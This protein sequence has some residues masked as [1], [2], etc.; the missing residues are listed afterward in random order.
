MAHLSAWHWIIVLFIAG[1]P[2]AVLG[3]IAWLVVRASRRPVAPATT[4][5]PPPASHRPSAESRLQELNDLKEKQL[6]TDAEYE[7]QRA[8]IL[9]GV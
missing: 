4:A 5:A 9:R 6:I 1:I 3:L 2:I 7:Q 8:S